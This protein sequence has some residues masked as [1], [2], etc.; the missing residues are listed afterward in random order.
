MNEKGPR[1][2]NAASAAS[3][4]APAR[5]GTLRALA[6][7]RPGGSR[8]GR[9]DSEPGSPGG[10]TRRAS[11]WAR[12]ISA[13]GHPAWR[14]LTASGGGPGDRDFELPP[15]SG[16]HARLRL[17]GGVRT[18]RASGCAVAAALAAAPG[19]AATASQRRPPQWQCGFRAGRYLTGSGPRYWH[20]PTG[21]K[22]LE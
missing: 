18:R 4:P 13:R 15:T 21:L 17:G 14:L 22:S 2:L 10:P 6:P 1:A 9:G 19:R 8:R 3:R 16:R 20:S 7:A 5:S 12:A 11:A